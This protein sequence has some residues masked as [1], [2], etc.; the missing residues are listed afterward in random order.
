[1][2]GFL[3]NIVSYGAE[4]LF[5]TGTPQITFFKIVYR[6]YTNFSMESI[7][8]DFDDEFGFGI[9][10]NLTL[11]TNGDLVYKTYLKIILPEMSF[12]RKISQKQIECLQMSYNYAIN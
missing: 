10:S 3:I 1:M 5:L 12:M 4:D 9:T 2:P 8:L 11:P 6:R 7:E